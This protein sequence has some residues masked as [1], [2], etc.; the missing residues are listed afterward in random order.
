MTD[1][2]HYLYELIDAVVRGN[3]AHSQKAAQNALKAGVPAKTAVLEGLAQGMRQVGSLYDSNE[4]FVPEVL[5][6]AEALYTGMGILR[7]HIE[8]DALLPPSKIVI[9]TVKGDIHDIGKNITKLMF[10]AAGWHVFDL[11][12]D[13]KLEDFVQAQQEV[14][15]DILAMSAMMT[16]TMMGMRKVISMVRAKNRDCLIMIGGAPVTRDI[17]DLFGAD[18]YAG[19][20]GTAVSEGLKMMERAAKIPC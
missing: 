8:S 4:Y 13:V 9:G 18:G 3:S 17:A 2:N 14:K 10:H 5:M 20:A 15:P 1:W 11:G 6:S 16:T 19:S 7:P 12:C